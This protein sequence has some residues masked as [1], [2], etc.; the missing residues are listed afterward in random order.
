MLQN[1]M[2][3]FEPQGQISR[4]HGAE[5][6]RAARGFI[7]QGV[8]QEASRLEIADLAAG[9]PGWSAPQPTDRIAGEIVPKRAF[10]GR[11]AQ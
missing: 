8:R 3:V 7:R 10:S 11:A 9:A 6:R 5:R 1:N 2:R 4:A